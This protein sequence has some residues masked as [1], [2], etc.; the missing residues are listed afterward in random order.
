MLKSQ[1]TNNSI[2]ITSLKTM[3]QTL[4]VHAIIYEMFSYGEPTAKDRMYM[5]NH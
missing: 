3:S 4:I 5:N 1:F 2:I